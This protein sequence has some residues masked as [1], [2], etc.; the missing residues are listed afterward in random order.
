MGEVEDRVCEAG[1]AVVVLGGTLGLLRA[2]CDKEG[3]EYK[4]GDVPG[5]VGGCR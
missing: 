1:A 3:A 2:A 4:D 5:L